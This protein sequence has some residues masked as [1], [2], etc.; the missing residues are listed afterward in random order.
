MTDTSD[1]VIRD[2]V[3]HSNAERTPVPPDPTLSE[4]ELATVKARTALLSAADQVAAARRAVDAAEEA[5]GQ[6]CANLLEARTNEADAMATH[7]A[8]LTALVHATNTLT[9]LAGRPVPA[10]HAG[11][12]LV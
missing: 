10:S 4:A 9:R 7:D 11:T 1:I 12:G 3:V 2:N 5:E 6:A 8:A